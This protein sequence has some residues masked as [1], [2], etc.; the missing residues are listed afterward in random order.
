MILK[1]CVKNSG[2]INKT[3]GVEILQNINTNSDLKKEVVVT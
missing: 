2:V 1:Q 3:S